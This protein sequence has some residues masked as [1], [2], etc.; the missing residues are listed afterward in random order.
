MEFC[1]LRIFL[2]I[3]LEETHT[4]ADSIIVQSSCS[5]CIATVETYTRTPRSFSAFVQNAKPFPSI[6]CLYVNPSHQ[7]HSEEGCSLNNYL[8]CTDELT[9]GNIT[10]IPVQRSSQ[11]TR[12]VSEKGRVSA[13]AQGKTKSLGRSKGDKV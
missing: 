6:R 9:R 3:Y 4:S 5:T 7:K 11:L 2:N 10:S 12:S 13:D 8:L 1:T